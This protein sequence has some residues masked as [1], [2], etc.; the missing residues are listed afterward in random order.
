MTPDERCAGE[1]SSLPPATISLPHHHPPNRHPENCRPL[2]RCPENRCPENRH[3]R[4]RIARRSAAMRGPG[5]A[6]AGVARERLRA[7]RPTARRGQA[8][9]SIRSRPA[10][11]CRGVSQQG[12]AARWRVRC[13]GRKA[14]RDGPS[15]RAHARRGTSPSAPGSWWSLGLWCRWM[16]CRA[17]R[18]SSGRARIRSTFL[19]SPAGVRVHQR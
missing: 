10:P 6:S 8:P 9:E 13:N 3:R 12:K 7:L 2:Q 16:A 14:I 4:G 17:L 19:P 11:G 1:E 15:G 18:R 5:P